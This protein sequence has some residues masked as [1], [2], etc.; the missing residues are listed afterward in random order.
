MDLTKRTK[1]NDQQKVEVGMKFLM[2]TNFFELDKNDFL[3][4]TSYKKALDEA[5]DE[6]DVVRNI[7][8][9]LIKISKE[10]KKNKEEI[11]NMTIMQIAIAD[12]EN[13]TVGEFL[14]EVSDRYTKAELM[15]VKIS[16]I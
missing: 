14:K 13:K 1:L 16:E 10:I 7:T 15:N 8:S 3:A 4:T 12:F 6:F 11:K 5:N 2:K 9:A